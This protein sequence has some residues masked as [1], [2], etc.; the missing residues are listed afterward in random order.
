MQFQ[1][2]IF[3]GSVG[4]L[5]GWSSAEAIYK[6]ADEWAVTPAES[7]APELELQEQYED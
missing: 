5:K 3:A 2:R 4:E 6:D 1:P 7:G